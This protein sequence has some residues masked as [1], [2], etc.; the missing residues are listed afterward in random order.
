MV[1]LRWLSFKSQAALKIDFVSSVQQDLNLDVVND[2]QW[3]FAYVII[4]DFDAM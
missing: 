1:A 2:V 4:P 3:K